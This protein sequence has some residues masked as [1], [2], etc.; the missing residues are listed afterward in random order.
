MKPEE[1]IDDIRRIIEE[2]RHR[3]YTLE[4]QLENFRKRITSIL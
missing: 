1:I 2:M 4:E 3:L